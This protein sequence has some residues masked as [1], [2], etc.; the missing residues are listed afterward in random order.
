MLER[1]INLS[2]RPNSRQKRHSNAN[3]SDIPLKFLPKNLDTSFDALKK[4]AHETQKKLDE[5]FPQYIFKEDDV[6]HIFHAV[7][8]DN[9]PIKSEKHIKA[10]RRTS[11]MASV[12][13]NE[14]TGQIIDSLLPNKIGYTDMKRL[15]KERNK[16]YLL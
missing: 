11:S 10:R 9:H 13:F 3:I 5:Y 4:M 1:K 8:H 15:L 12:R 2:S 14:S 6:D 7:K 16:E